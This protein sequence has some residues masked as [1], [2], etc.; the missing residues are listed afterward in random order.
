MIMK[1]QTLRQMFENFCIKG[2][3]KVQDYIPR[4]VKLVNQMRGLDD[5]IFKG[6]GGGKSVEELRREV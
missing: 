6:H 3:E 4:V 2:N 1:L 5:N